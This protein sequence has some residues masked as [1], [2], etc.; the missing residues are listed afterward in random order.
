MHMYFCAGYERTFDDKCQ[1][2]VMALSALP[3]YLTEL[4]LHPSMSDLQNTV[5]A[6]FTGNHM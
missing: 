5:N 2:E 1:G 3:A 6:V 4:G